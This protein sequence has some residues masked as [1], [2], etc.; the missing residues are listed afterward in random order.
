VEGINAK[1]VVIDSISTFLSETMS[2]EQVRQFLI[3]L[4][5][6]FKA[7][8]ITC[9]MNHIFPLSFAAERGQLLSSLS[10]TQMRLSSL[11]DGLVMLLFVERGQKVKKLINV[12][13]LRGSQHSKEILSYEIEKGGIKMGVKFEE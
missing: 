13:K 4:S 11:T 10:N 7:N 12:L 2:E 3:Q 6:Y 8:G 9:I 5:G 1:R